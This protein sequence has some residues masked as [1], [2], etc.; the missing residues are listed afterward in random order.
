[1]GKKKTKT[2]KKTVKV[3]KMNQ[4]VKIVIGGQSKSNNTKRRKRTTTKQNLPQAQLIP[5]PQTFRSANPD[6][7]LLG[8]LATIRTSVK[9]QQAKVGQLDEIKRDVA[10]AYIDLTGNGIDAKEEKDFR[11]FL[12]NL[13]RAGKEGLISPF[14]TPAKTP[15]VKFGATPQKP[16]ET[17]IRPN[18]NFRVQDQ[19]KLAKRY[20]VEIPPE[21]QALIDADQIG[22]KKQAGLQKKLAKFINEKLDEQEAVQFQQEEFAKDVPATTGLLEPRRGTLDDSFLRE[23]DDRRR[24]LAEMLGEQGSETAR[25]GAGVEGDPELSTVDVFDNDY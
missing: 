2:T 21:L 1:M 13:D 18:Q 22:G 11:K 9:E 17:P 6:A 24:R 4:V 7:S 19:V 10:R 23:I 8:E 20:N 12:G 15:R 3:N 16:T 25:G 5:Q 14:T